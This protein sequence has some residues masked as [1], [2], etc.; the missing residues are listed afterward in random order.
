[1]FDNMLL[2]LLIQTDHLGV[3]IYSHVG[4]PQMLQQAKKK[5]S[6]FAH[7]FPQTKLEFLTISQKKKSLFINLYMPPYSCLQCLYSFGGLYTG[8]RGWGKEFSYKEI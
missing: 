5:K 8:H 2:T 6:H 7:C 4:L 1:M 3:Y